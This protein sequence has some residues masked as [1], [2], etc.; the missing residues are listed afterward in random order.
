VKSF[1]PL[2]RCLTSPIRASVK[3]VLLSPAQ[4][5]R[6]GQQILILDKSLSLIELDK[7]KDQLE[8][9][10][11]SVE[12]LKFQLENESW[13][14]NLD[15]QIKGLSIKSPKNRI[16]RHPPSVQSRRPYPKKTSAAPKTPLKFPNWKRTSS[17]TRYATTV[18][19]KVP[20]SASRNYKYALKKTGSKNSSTNSKCA[21]LVADR[22][23]THL[24]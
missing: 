17:K 18:S 24:G 8:L 11:N 7:L 1:L 19:L 21:D 23:G 4:P 6:P 2:N 22:R 3:Q 16:G 15:N 20:T 13:T 14:Q 10:R 12:K 9:K 5:V